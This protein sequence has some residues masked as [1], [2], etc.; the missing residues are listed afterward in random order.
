MK[1]NVKRFRGI[2]GG[3]ASIS[4]MADGRAKLIV[5]NGYGDRVINKVYQ[6]ER[7]AKIAMG[8]ASDGWHE[9]K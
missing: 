9:I 4:V 7:G 8:K 6:S 3:T 5:C 1:S 2:Y